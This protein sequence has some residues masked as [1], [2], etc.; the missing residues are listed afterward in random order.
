MKQSHIIQ[1]KFDIQSSQQEIR[2]VKKNGFEDTQNIS[3]NDVCF[4]FD[5]Y[6]M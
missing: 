2:K 4:S 1:F 6:T 3:N 5:Y